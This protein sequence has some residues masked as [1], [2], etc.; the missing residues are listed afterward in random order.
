MSNTRLLEY[1]LHEN[2]ISMEASRIKNVIVNLEWRRERSQ[3]LTA[4]AFG[5]LLF[6]LLYV[7]RSS[8][9]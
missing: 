7:F 6:V 8:L 1:V 3:R 2:Y 5:A 9:L 4:L